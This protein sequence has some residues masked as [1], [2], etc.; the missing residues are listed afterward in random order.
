MLLLFLIS[1][2]PFSFSMYFLPISSYWDGIFVLMVTTQPDIIYRP[3]RLRSCLCLSSDCC[4]HLRHRSHVYHYLVFIVLTYYSIGSR[5]IE[6]LGHV[7]RRSNW[8]LSL[9]FV[10][11]PNRPLMID[12]QGQAN[13]W[14]KNS[15]KDNQLSVREHYFRIWQRFQFYAC[16][17][18]CCSSA[19][20]GP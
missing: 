3:F 13:K 9:S 15:E 20:V 11:T 18:T 4:H 5:T 10:F 1:H 19:W 17:E 6:S 7:R 8:F 12:P 16:F 2:V 14:I